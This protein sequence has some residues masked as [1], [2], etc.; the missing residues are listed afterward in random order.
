MLKAL[1]NS[2][3]KEFDFL[4]SNDEFK[5]EW[6]TKERIPYNLYVL[7]LS[8][9][10]FVINEEDEEGVLPVYGGGRPAAPWENLT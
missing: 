9:S 10:L 4:T 7:R 3:I 6:T 8:I 1:W 5:G 2:K